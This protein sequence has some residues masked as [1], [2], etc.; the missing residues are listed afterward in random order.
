LPF[1][2]LSDMSENKKQTNKWTIKR[3]KK[4]KSIPDSSFRVRW[5]WASYQLY[6]LVHSCHIWI[7]GSLNEMGMSIHNEHL[8]MYVCMGTHSRESLSLLGRGIVLSSHFNIG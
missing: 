3:T 8:Y 5:N 7:Q 2:L 1:F 6:S 4:Y